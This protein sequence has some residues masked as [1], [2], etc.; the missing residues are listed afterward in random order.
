MTWHVQYRDAGEDR[1]ERHPS[2]EQAIEA[3]C[4]LLDHGC[5]VFGI[6]TG[7]I[8]DSIGRDQIARI[9]ALWAR[10]K[11]PA[12]RISNRATAKPARCIA[13]SAS[14]I[15][16]LGSGMILRQCWQRPMSLPMS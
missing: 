5:D 10:A 11:P 9:Y 8:T 4:H 7:P 12:G 13:G 15:F 3:A 2:P 1:I 14:T 6:G 16:S